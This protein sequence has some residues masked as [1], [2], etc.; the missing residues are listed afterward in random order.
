MPC[1]ETNLD[2]MSTNASCPPGG[3]ELPDLN[4][5]PILHN[6]TVAA[7]PGRNSSGGPMQTCCAPNPVHVLWD[8]YEW[9][10][11]PSSRLNR[12]SHAAVID[13]FNECLDLN[14]L[15]ISQSSILGLQFAGSPGRP[16]LTMTRLGIWAILMLGVLSFI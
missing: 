2:S 8:C 12:S 7:I 9:C 3:N 10:E 4:T 1:L 6:V 16:A 14:G 15:N 11:V 5:L 13:D